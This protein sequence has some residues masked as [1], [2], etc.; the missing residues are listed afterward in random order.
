[1]AEQDGR[2]D[3]KIVTFNC[4]RAFIDIDHFANGLFSSHQARESPDLLVLCLEEVAPVAHAFLGRSFLA[5]YTTR[6]VRAVQKASKESVH[7]DVIIAPNVGLTCLMLFAKPDARARVQWVETAGVG[8]GRWEMGNKGAV[9]TRVGLSTESQASV[10]EL[11]FV[12]AHLAAGAT[13]V[14][15]RN[16]DWKNV[17]RGLV[18]QPSKKGHTSS[19]PGDEHEP[20]LSPGSGAGSSGILSGVF[21]GSSPVFLAGDLNYRTSDSGPQQGDFEKFPQPTANRD[22]PQHWSHIRPKDQLDRERRTGKTMHS[23]DEAKIDFPPTYKYDNARQQ[24]NKPNGSEPDQYHWASHRWPGWC[25]RILYSSFLSKE[26]IIDTSNYDALPL[27]S[28]S[29]HRPVALSFTLDLHALRN[30]PTVVHAPFELNKQW[31]SDR[32]AAR[33]MEFVVGCLA[34]VGLTWEGRALLAATIV[35]IIG[36]WLVIHSLVDA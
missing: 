14:E 5:P 33:R 9:G 1:M 10:V 16:D 30:T 3:V 21:K 8:V 4:G 17:V 24:L 15:R 25:D 27:Q 26:S 28:T 19:V 20:L 13:E 36:G 23:M 22:D 34:Y 35:G 31:K 18:F 32:I 11:T 2:L 29:D 12:A 6:F 7:Y